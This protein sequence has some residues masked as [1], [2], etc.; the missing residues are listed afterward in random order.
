MSAGELWSIVSSIVSIILA[1]VAIGLAVYFFVV[2]RNTET[3]VGSSLTKIET[4]AEMLQRLTGRQ[5][6]RL[7]KFVTEDKRPADDSRLTEF[8][9]LVMQV[10]KPLTEGVSLP[11]AAPCGFRKL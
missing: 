8:L 7:T 9:A 6:D 4:Q 1:I 3:R 5:L 10:A 2:G 11:A